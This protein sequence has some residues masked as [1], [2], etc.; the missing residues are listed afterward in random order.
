M[1]SRNKKQVNKYVNYEYSIID[2]GII[3][4]DYVLKNKEMDEDLRKS[5]LKE[6]RLFKKALKEKRVLDGI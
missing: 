3:Y 1:P 5:I 2:A 6:R 4:C